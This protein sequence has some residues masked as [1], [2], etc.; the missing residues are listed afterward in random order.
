MADEETF[1]LPFSH[2]LHRRVWTHNLNLAFL[3]SHPDPEGVKRH[4]A[5]EYN[6]FQR[7]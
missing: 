4:R 1:H 5:E 2:L 7:R 3:E 6:S